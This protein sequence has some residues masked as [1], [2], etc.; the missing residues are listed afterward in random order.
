[1]HIVAIIMKKCAV[2]NFS[3]SEPCMLLLKVIL[4]SSLLEIIDKIATF[5]ALI[6]IRSLRNCSTAVYFY[7]ELYYTGGNLQCDWLMIVYYVNIT[8]I[9]TYIGVLYWCTTGVLQHHIIWCTLFCLR[10]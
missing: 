2:L 5:R 7:Y 8:Y 9:G 4:I 3:K 6:C 1:M 10:I